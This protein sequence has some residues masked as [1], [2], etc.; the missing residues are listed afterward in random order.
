MGHLIQG[1]NSLYANKL[2][3]LI[4]GRTV[5]SPLYSG[6]FW[7]VQDTPLEDIARIEVIRGP[8]STLWG[9]NAVNG[10]INITTMRAQET[11]GGMVSAGAGNLAREDVTVRYG[12]KLGDSTYYRIYGKSLDRSGFVD[13]AGK[14]TDDAWRQQRGGFRVDSEMPGGAAL[15]LAGEV[16]SGRSGYMF[17]L[18]SLAPPFCE[19]LLRKHQD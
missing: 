4:D 7:D 19:F 16:Y 5:Y 6:V 11:Q 2:L 12:G 10:V 8:G 3:V 9:A 18:P 15:T 13:A 17:S 14:A 1:F